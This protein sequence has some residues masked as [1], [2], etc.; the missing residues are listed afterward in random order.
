MLKAIPLTA[1]WDESGN[2]VLTVEINL[3]QEQISF[4]EAFRICRQIE[5]LFT[6]NKEKEAEQ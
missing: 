3:P 2:V 4:P 6:E 1:S 5:T